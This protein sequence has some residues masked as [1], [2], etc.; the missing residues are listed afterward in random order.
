MRGSA[1]CMGAATIVNAIPT[2]KGAAFGIT[3]EADAEVTLSESSDE[4]RFEGPSEGKDLVEGCVRSVLGRPTG[5][6]TGIRVRVVS[7]IPISRGLKSSSAVSNAVVMATARAASLDL[8]D[9]DILGIAIDESLKAGVTVTGAFDDSAACYLGGVVM[10]DN[11]ERRILRRGKIDASL[12]V[13]VHVPE[14]KITKSS[15]RDTDF[16]STKQEFEQA[17]S[18]ALA[19]EYS[20]AIEI[21]SRACAEAFGL[22][23]DLARSARELGA[24]AAGISGTGPATI[25]LAK[26]HDLGRLK[27][28]FLERGDGRVLEARLNETPA[29]EVA[30]RLL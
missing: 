22:S 1:A 18:H 20:R 26:S 11:K 16:S 6:T 29:K 15:I 14:R 27:S 5:R 2:G 21:N 4:F 3:L 10:T 12:S 9:E 25:A 8:E 17:F 24:V 30:P 23:E 19:G 28:L 13:L 7:D